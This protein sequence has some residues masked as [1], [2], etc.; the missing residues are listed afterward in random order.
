MFIVFILMF[1]FCIVLKRIYIKVIISFS[2]CLHIICLYIVPGYLIVF[3]F[4][5]YW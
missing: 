2:F 1:Y 5:D 3:P 4:L